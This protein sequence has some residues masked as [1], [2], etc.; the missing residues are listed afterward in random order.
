MVTLYA[1]KSLINHFGDYINIIK[2]KQQSHIA[3]VK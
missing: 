2:E 3:G 1:L